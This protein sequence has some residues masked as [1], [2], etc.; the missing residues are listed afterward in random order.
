MRIELERILIH[1]NERLGL[2]DEG[3]SRDQQIDLFKRFLKVESER[4]RIRHR[5]GVGGVEVARGRSYLIDLVICRVC[6][7]AASEMGSTHPSFGPCSMIALGGYGRKE[8]APFS[9]VDLLFLHAGKKSDFTETYVEKVLRFLWDIGLTVGHSFRSLSDCADMAR[10]DLHSSTAMSEARLIAGNPH[11]FRRLVRA[12]N[13]SVYK[14]RQEAGAFLEAL[15]RE[16][17]VRY[18]RFGA[19]VCV[20]EPHIK[21]GAGGLRDLHTALWVG[22][23]RYGLARLDDLRAEDAISGAEYSTVRRAYDFIART[24]NETHFATGRATDLLNLNLQPQIAAGLGYEPKRGLLASEI[25]MRDYYQ[26]A[27][28]LNEFCTAFFSRAMESRRSKRNSTRMQIAAS[29]EVRQGRLYLTTRKCRRGE[30]SIQPEFEIR[31]DKLYIRNEPQDF[32]SNPMR[33]M[34]IFA[35]AQREG[36]TPGEETR[37]L[38]RGNL[39]IVNRTFRSSR[40]AVISLIDMLR[41]KGR[42]APTLRAMRETGFLGRFIPEFARISFLVQH[43]FYHKYTID[44]HTLKAI[45]AIDQLASPFNDRLAPLAQVFAEIEDTAPLYIGV[46][47][48]DIGKGEGEGHVLRGVRKA[49]SICERLGLNEQLS[50]HIL[51]LVRHH[52]LMAHLSQRRDLSEDHL[53]EDFAATVG[54]LDRLNSLLLLTYADI[55]GVGP[56]V[57]NDWKG[58]LLWELY[59]RARS[60]LTGGSTQ[61]GY[62][63]QIA[64]SVADELCLDYPSNKVEQHMALL[65]ERYLRAVNHSQIASHIRLIDRLDEDSFCSGWREADDGEWT[66]LTVC[67]RDSAGL[68][69]RMAGTLTASGL[70]ILSADIYTREDGIALDI[71]RVSEVNSNQGLRPERRAMVERNLKNALEGIYDVEAAVERRRAKA[72]RP[73]RINKYFAEPKPAVRFDAKASSTC[74][75]IEVEA[76]DEMGLAYKISNALSALG[77][78]IAFAK[79]GTE[80]NLALDVFY[81]T[82]SAGS[83]LTPAGMELVERALIDAL[84]GSPK[85]KP[86][87][88]AV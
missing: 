31:D 9:D 23:A 43:D 80:K 20:Q 2:L 6:N 34:E 13:E 75:V 71:F 53:I 77:L 24:R 67:A 41:Q 51:F 39:S 63:A 55:N 46:L 69:A 70:N 85:D 47:L 11:L 87:K 40:M 36:V 86:I 27:Q 35:V 49:E 81:V 54:S 52:L 15:G 62:V 73:A 66:E 26:R 48:H 65:P 25:F 64:E 50:N 84:G 18:Q 10:S 76:R 56:G 82:D 4:L 58:S 29:Y 61:W 44:E 37:A 12:L 42:V 45:E 28:E 74:T 1:A 78:Q 19:A 60:F 38:I 21:A 59:S 68:F 16:L 14:N 5:F 17:E 7:L 72:S 33:M 3:L 79:I 22:H 88:Q 83:K 57:W 32:R 30:D 8:L